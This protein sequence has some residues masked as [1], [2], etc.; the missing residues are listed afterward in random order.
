MPVIAPLLRP[1]LLPPL[2]PLEGVVADV[3]EVDVG[4][5]EGFDTGTAVDR[6]VE[7]EV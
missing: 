2:F 7:E 6:K 1:P 4:E 3:G 5:M